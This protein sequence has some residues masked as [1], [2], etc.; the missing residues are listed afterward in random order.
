MSAGSARWTTYLYAA[1][2]AAFIFQ[3]VWDATQGSWTTIVA[4]P[5]GFLLSEWFLAWYRRRRSDPRAD[6][7]SAAADHP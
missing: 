7:E 1:V 3:V 6:E 5:L 2:L 4:I